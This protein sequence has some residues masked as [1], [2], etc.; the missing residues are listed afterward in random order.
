MVYLITGR[1]GS[2]KTHH[3]QRLI[4]DLQSR[5]VPALL[6][7]G[8]AVRWHFDDRDFSD[9][10]RYNHLMR[11][12]KMAAIVENQDFVVVVACVSPKKKWRQ[13]MRSLWRQS[14]LVYM[15]GGSLWEGTEYE[16]PD[17]EELA[18]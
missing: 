2:G 18:K 7:D 12:A 1:A 13:E 5:G 10:G 17:L 6:L 14:T 15:P 9:E 3:A 4:L 16:V 8:D 11:M